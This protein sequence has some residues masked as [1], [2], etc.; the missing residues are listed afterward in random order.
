MGPGLVEKYSHHLEML[1]A[2]KALSKEDILTALSFGGV[3]SL[4]PVS[5]MMNAE[6]YIDVIQRKIVRDMQTEF[7]DDGLFFS[8]TLTDV[9]LLKKRRNCCK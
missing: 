6:K 8:K 3:G 2:R 5:G 7:P 9:M 1:F 4:Y